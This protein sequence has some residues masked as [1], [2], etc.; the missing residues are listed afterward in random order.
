MHVGY[1]LEPFFLSILGRKKSGPNN[2][3]HCP[4]KVIVLHATTHFQKN[5]NNNNLTW[6][7]GRLLPDSRSQD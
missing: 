7:R 3:C 1:T 4:R 5:P 2:Y 6:G